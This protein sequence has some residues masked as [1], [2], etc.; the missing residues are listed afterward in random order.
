ML[1]G[2]I[3]VI[4]FFIIGMVM[5]NK[6]IVANEVDPMQVTGTAAILVERSTG[7][8]IFEQNPD[9]VI[10][11]ASMTK[12]LTAIVALDYIDEDDIV[13]VGT[14]IN[15]VPAGS[16][17][18]GHILGEHVT[19]LNLIRGLI[20]P[21]GNDTANI[22]AAHVAREHTGNENLGFREAEAIF[23]DLM[24]QRAKEIGA[25][26]SN[27]ANAHGFHDPNLYTTVRD[28]A[29]IAAV[30]MEHEAIMKVASEAVFTGNSGGGFVG[31]G[32]RTR[33]IDWF[34]HN[35][36][37]AG[38]F[39]NT[40]VTGLK[41]GFTDQAGFCLIGTAERNGVEL[42]S[43]IA[44]SVNPARWTDTTALFQY[45]FNNY[46]LRTVQ[47]TIMSLGEIDLYNAR[48]GDETSIQVFGDKNFIHFLTEEEMQRI[49]RSV[50]YDTDK[51]MISETEED[52]AII[53][54][55]APLTAGQVIGR[56]TYNLD[57]E[58]LFTGNVIVTQDVYERTF[59][60]NVT[61]V[62]NYL[63]ANAVSIY[64][65]SFMLLCISFGMM[66]HKVVTVL[67]NRSKKI[68]R[69]RK[70]KIKYHL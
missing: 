67:R 66:L 34:T 68:N 12:V 7:R 18:A 21:S 8:V 20:M 3:S 41:T 22:V 65:L 23:T 9:L 30:A 14:E 38:P 5:T 33:E 54:L 60:S 29:K 59:S 2:K 28:L 53:E 45:G 49:E 13:V 42:I 10:Y 52:D 63:Q 57:G 31:E 70:N 46:S 19:G 15:Y 37:L 36:L 69:R 32:V 47:H 43:V 64:G 40:Y 55:I 6:N 62:V 35:R 25:V 27:F 51:I 17:R 48:W 58:T 4:M 1:K 11:P 39:Y 56:V 61:Y 44:G 50:I 24:N 16:S 26:N